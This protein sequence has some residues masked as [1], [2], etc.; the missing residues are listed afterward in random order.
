MWFH[1]FFS[2]AMRRGLELFHAVFKD[3]RSHI[4]CAS[5]VVQRSLYVLSQDRFASFNKKWQQ[6][7]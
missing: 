3:G 7:C 1:H 2:E 6:M 5:N 4:G